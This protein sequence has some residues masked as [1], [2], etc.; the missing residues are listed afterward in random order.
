MSED[1]IRKVLQLY[2]G[3]NSAAI[4]YGDEVYGYYEVFNEYNEKNKN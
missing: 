3:K 4:E 2:N 1:E